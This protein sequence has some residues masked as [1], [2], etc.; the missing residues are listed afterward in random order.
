M[1]VTSPHFAYKP[2]G[3]GSAL[4]KQ[5]GFGKMLKVNLKHFF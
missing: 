4:G 3:I 2:G 5:G 1:L